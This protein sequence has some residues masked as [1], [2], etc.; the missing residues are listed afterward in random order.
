MQNSKLG[1]ALFTLKAATENIAHGII[2]RRMSS[3]NKLM[4]SFTRGSGLDETALT[5]RT[6]KP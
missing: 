2:L 5:R 6:P 1:Q 4:R 3:M